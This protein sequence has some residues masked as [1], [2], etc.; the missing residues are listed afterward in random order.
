MRNRSLCL[1]LGVAM[2]VEFQSAAAAQESVRM[3]EPFTPDKRYKVELRVELNGRMAVPDGKDKPPR[4]VPVTGTSTLNYDERILP[5]DDR[6]AEKVIRLYR[7]VEFRRTVGGV[8]QQAG[9]RTAVRRMV[10]LRSAKGKAPFSP[11]GPL[12]WG[13]IDVVRTDVFSPALVTGVLPDKAVRP[14]DSWPLSADAVRELTDM[15][16]VDAG[17]FTATFVG[18]V[19]LDNR[20]FA[21]LGFV[22]TVKGVDDV[23]PGKH[24]I[25]GTGYF[26]LGDGMLT[27]L[28]LKAT[29][30]LLNEAGQ[31]AGRIDGQFVLSRGPAGTADDLSDTALKAI[32]LKP[33]ADNSQLLYDNPDLGV[34]FLYPRRW[35]VGAV[36]GRQVTLDGPNGAGILLTVEPPARLPTAA[37]YLAET[38]EFLNKQKAAVSGVTRPAR[39]A[40]K[41][42]QL[43]RFGLDADL[44]GDKV[45]MEYAVLAQ[46]EGGVTVAA[47]LPRQDAAALAGDLD[48]VLN[49]LMLTKPV[50]GR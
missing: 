48:R 38:E 46:T 41:P 44:G 39:A 12:T 30:D 29:H 7:T 25:E 6:D 13:E 4:I 37:A 20:E 42:F 18:V 24:T 21:R 23:G 45:R 49:R 31:V 16:K 5:P 10:V 50:A 28:S 15:D 35:R 11:D 22:G 43:D 17:G 14:G 40:E 33:T 26:S 34:R 47:R 1:L 32:D 3:S 27:R 2:A 19:R 36:Q 9:I 8:D